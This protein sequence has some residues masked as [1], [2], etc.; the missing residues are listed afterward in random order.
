MRREVSDVFDAVCDVCV[1]SRLVSVGLFTSMAGAVR[2]G[3]YS[4]ERERK[5]CVPIFCWQW[6][7]T[8][9]LEVAGFFDALCDACIVSKG[10]LVGCSWVWMGQ[11]KKKRRA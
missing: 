7:E 2:G 3:A 6:R 8:K 11:C 4:M 10:C 9:R 1:M 5:L